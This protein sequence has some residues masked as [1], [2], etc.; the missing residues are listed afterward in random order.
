MSLDRVSAS[1]RDPSGFLFKRN[2]V[3]YRQINKQYESD[4][5]L[6][7][8]SGLYD[9]LSKSGLLIRHEEV[10]VQAGESENA[11]KVIRPQLLRFVSYP[12][13]WSFSQLK[14]A[15][16][17]T[18]KIQKRALRYGMSLKDASA[19]NIQFQEGRAVLIDTLSFAAYKEDDPWLAYK[20][21]CQHFL[22]TL[23]LMSKV[24]VRLS[25][26]LR[27]H[28]DGIPLDLASRMLPGAT[29][30]DFGLL[31]H[32]HLHAKA[33]KKY[34]DRL[35]PPSNINSGKM[36]KSSMLGLIESLESAVAKLDWN[37]IGT[38]WVDYYNLTNYSDE[39][40]GYKKKILGEWVTRIN[41]ESVWDLG[42]NIGV[43]ARIA[44]GRGIPVIAFDVD[45]A[46]V[47]KNY[48]MVK[49]NSEKGVLPL[50]QDLVNPS[51]SL[52]WRNRERDSLFDRAPAGMIFALALIHHLAISNNVPLELLVDF[53][54]SLG[55]WL[56]IE[57]VPK[58]DSQVQ[59]LLASRADIFDR[60]TLEDFEN[61]FQERYI[62]HEKFQIP[63]TGRIL[64][65]MAP[66]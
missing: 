47:E 30:F 36:S 4:Y 24:D 9:D 6:L 48:R 52:G 66:R 42:A 33:I 53:F 50:L 5:K 32:V 51:P 60:Y 43:F 64:Y 13:E 29:W 44:S 35:A 61:C 15:A 57:F 49:S 3:L 40:L 10:D 31:V 19:Y 55:G 26:L 2:G 59:K 14:D 46:A 54:H 62:I 22:A 11:F 65:L 16:L 41:P 20:Q 37:P 21:F 34:T 1:F 17:V 28:V 7:I 27:V 56:A 39:S 25:Q 63:K 12:Y 23:A 18:L 38:E 58:T 8:G 45:P